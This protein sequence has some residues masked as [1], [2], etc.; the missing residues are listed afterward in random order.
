MH[1]PYIYSYLDGN[2]KSLLS[3]LVWL[4]AP[5]DMEEW[6]REDEPGIAVGCA[7]EYSGYQKVD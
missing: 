1:G 6:E 2:G 3:C 5:A 7:L 4:L